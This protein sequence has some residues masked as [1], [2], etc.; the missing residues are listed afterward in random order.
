MYKYCVY[1]YIMCISV[2]VYISVLSVLVYMKL[3]LPTLSLQCLQL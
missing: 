1:M 2:Y 3:I